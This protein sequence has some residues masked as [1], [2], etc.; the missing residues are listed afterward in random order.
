[1]GKIL[2]QCL[3]ESTASPG[4]RESVV[5][6]HGGREHTALKLQTP[7]GGQKNGFLFTE[8]CLKKDPPP[9]LPQRPRG[10]RR[11]AAAGEEW[12]LETGPGGSGAPASSRS[13]TWGSPR[14]A[15]RP[16]CSPAV[17]DSP[18]ARP[19]SAHSP[20]KRWADFAGNLN[21]Q[22]NGSRAPH[23]G[24][25]LGPAGPPSGVSKSIGLTQVRATS[26]PLL[27]RPGTAAV[28]TA[29]QP[30]P[31]QPA[32]PGR[33]ADS[34]RRRRCG[35]LKGPA[36]S[37]AKPGSVQ[38]NSPEHVMSR[39]TLQEDMTWSG[40]EAYTEGGRVATNV[41]SKASGWRSRRGSEFLDFREKIRSW[42]SHTIF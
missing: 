1:M 28:S 20:R 16:S 12:S 10:G 23:L 41:R 26:G 30:T 5:L 25:A 19:D 3:G 22:R 21:F 7:S 24:P 27:P 17:R 31:S 2:H 29:T 15:P 14:A 6:Q 35:A 38:N 8:I 37:T 18:P 40:L 36:P 9:V 32:T 33:P 34:P 42:C 39:C 13:E 4:Q 11:A